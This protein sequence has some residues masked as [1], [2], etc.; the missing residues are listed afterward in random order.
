[1]DSPSPNPAAEVARPRRAETA[2]ATADAALRASDQERDQ[3]AALLGEALATGRLTSVEH[4]ERIDAVYAARTLGELVPLT[5]D[6]PAGRTSAG[7]GTDPATT[8]NQRV[9]AVFSKV[10]RNGRW[11]T[12]RHTE[13]R[14][15]FGALIVDL[16]EAVLPGREIVLEA[17]AFCGKLIVTVP[18]NARIV[19]EGGALFGKRLVVGGRRTREPG[20]GTAAEDDGPLIR[21]TGQVRFSKIVIHRAHS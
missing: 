18:A 14:S 2:P 21:V 3:V 9:S 11:V 20:A 7:P 6:L 17:N 8:D 4:A 1:M 13:L 16:S 10:N 19:D 15:T 5:A 12:G